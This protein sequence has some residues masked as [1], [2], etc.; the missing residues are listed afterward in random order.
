MEIWKDI[1]GYEGHYQ[2]SNR[3]QVVNVKTK[4]I[5]KQFFNYGKYLRIGIKD[6][7]KKRNSLV[8]H[9][10]VAQAFIPNPENKPCVNHKNGIK[11]DNNVENLEWVTHKENQKHAF[12]TG[13]NKANIRRT[14]LYAEDINICF[15]NLTNFAKY[16]VENNLS[17]S[18]DYDNVRGRLSPRIKKENSIVY[19]IKIRRI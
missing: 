1:K 4:R 2:V 15:Y 16:I 19:G 12:N 7:N 6:R 14:K 17:R 18:S 8:I 5:L 13:L 9:R 3:G 11:K 10:L